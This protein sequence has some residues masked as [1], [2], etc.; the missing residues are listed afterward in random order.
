MSDETT[1]ERQDNELAALQA[2]YG[3]DVT[4]NRQNLPWKIWRPLDIM[5]KLNPLHNSDLKD[6]DCY[7][8]LHIECCPLYPDRPP[9]IAI[10]K[11][12]GLSIENGNK[13]L[14]ELVTLASQ[15][16]GEVM[17]FELAQHA[18][19]FLH[20]HHKPIFSFHEERLI[21][22]KEME[23]LKQQDLQ[24]KTSEERQ[25]MKDEI[26]KRK[27]ML[28]DAD[29]RV[30]R[31]STSQENSNH[32]HGDAPELVYYA[33]IKL[34]PTKKTHRIKTQA[35]CTC[36][37]KRLQVLRIAQRNNRKVYIGNCLGHSSN[38]A[39][40]Y[41]AID[42]TG[43]RLIAK[44]WT[45]SAVSDFQ[46]IQHYHQ[47]KNII[48]QELNILSRLKHQSL[49]PYM[50]METV[51]ETK[52]PE[53]QSYY[54][55]RDFVNGCSLKYLLSLCKF[56]DKF[57]A[58]KLLRTVG[59]GVF[60]ALK[61]LHSVSVM[62][63]DL[64]SEN[65]FVDVSGVVKLVGAGL[66]ARLAEIHEGDS[67]CN[68]QTQAQ[69]ICA[70]AQLLLSILSHEGTIHEVPTDLPGT[71]KD[72]FSRCLTDDE[73]SQ[74]TAEQLVN[75]IFLVDQP[76]Q[77]SSSKQKDEGSG[78]EDD[79]QVKKI[80]NISPPTDG[81]SRLKVEFEVLTWLG[82]G[83]FGD[84]VKVRNKLDDG[85]Y[86]I[87]RIKLNPESVQ[88]NKKITREVKLL[89]R[90]NHE[91]V[92]RYYNA[93]IESTL[94]APENEE[95]STVKSPTKKKPG[96]SL[97]Q[98]V[99]KLG[100]VKVEWSISENVTQARS[101]DSEDDDEEED[102]DDD[103]DYDDDDEQLYVKRV[104]SIMGPDESSSGIEFEGGSNQSETIP[105]ED[106]PD[107]PRP[108]SGRLHQVLFIQMEFCEKHTLRQAIDSGLYQEHFRAWRLF[109][110]IV[111]GLAHVHQK[112][113]IHRDLKPV[114]IFLDSNDHVKIGDFGL[115]T[116]ALGLPVDEKA[117]QQEE[118][119]GSLTGQ[120]G[121]ALY[122]APELLQS[123]G[124]VIYNQK[125]DIY[126]LGIILFEMFHPPIS[127]GTE[128]IVVLTNLRSKDIIMPKSF[129]TEENAK[130]IH[131][132]KWLLNHNAS[133]RPTCV[134]LL[135]SE[136]VPRPVPEGA[137]SG[138]L[139]HTLN[140]RK[141][142][143]YQRLIAACLDQRLSVAEDITYHGEVKTK[144]MDVLESLKD[145]VVR[146]FKSH[147]A[148]EFCPPLLMPRSKCWD[149][150]PNAVKVMTASGAVCHLP[151]DLRLP[152]ARHIAYSGI[153]YMRRYIVDT[154]YREK[155]VLG[156]HPREIIECAFDIV[157]PKTGT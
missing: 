68:R 71:A 15:H 111:E 138:L 74:W 53:K 42:E 47:I 153:K 90:L 31:S 38:G 20:D 4:D 116:K 87:K 5:L 123:V 62:H 65:V 96:D 92:V 99:A 146:V 100:E 11:I 156:F 103:D 33:D 97:E 59:V 24:S 80:Y 61:E 101:S 58:L 150:H 82:K 110:E 144:P 147:G 77:Q 109:R 46:T 128:R 45:I 43:E 88:L 91:N 117:K 76:V 1:E 81:H 115:A 152:F 14:S 102:D 16:C 141:A 23:Q 10:D 34:S 55:F 107:T 22:Q 145:I 13:L 29:K 2:I 136:H 44:K 51:K 125:V 140:E 151:H 122:V 41:L 94:E 56:S 37:L 139:A 19:Q 108:Q 70:A 52:R 149:Q 127:T 36:N 114:N 27:E 121:T 28:R 73:H 105:S 12:H 6:V 75:H 95:S 137:L 50:Y 54:V 131:V 26:E 86:A 69:D 79:E 67:Y 148:T 21:H 78:S 157:T 64:R 133:L 39:T 84:V 89:S 18:Q 98:V 130:Q 93:W 154:V 40:T 112:G 63:R 17:I 3:D 35:V 129:E 118:I 132:I 25:K 113:M 66:D 48:Q 57:E 32:S 83:A 155:H 85:F 120:V 30:H 8:T 142:R 7:I 106:V 72:F 119:G 143:A 49:V 126:S 124:K 135:A 104:R 134:E 9:K 60:E